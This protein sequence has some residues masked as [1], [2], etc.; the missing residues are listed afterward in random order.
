[1][2]MTFKRHEKDIQDFCERNGYDFEKAKHLLQC[3]GHEVLFLQYVD[4]DEESSGLG[5]LDE[6]PLP[7]VLAIYKR[8]NGQLMFK[9]TEY[10]DRYLSYSK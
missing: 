10:T 6:T 4:P 3:G 9:K 5:L 2:I 7:L 1:M 8:T